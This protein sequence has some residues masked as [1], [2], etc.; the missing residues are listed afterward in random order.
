MTVSVT[1]E[2]RM[3]PDDPQISIAS[4]KRDLETMRFA[5]FWPPKVECGPM[6]YEVLVNW[7]IFGQNF[8]AKG[9]VEEHRRLANEERMRQELLL[10]L[11]DVE[12]NGMPVRLFHDVPDGRFWPSREPG[13][14][15]SR[16][17]AGT[18]AHD[19]FKTTEA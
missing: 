16:P 3:P 12:F 4:L 18:E 10:G 2:A 15:N 13:S 5:G 19:A 1:R 6:V 11:T 8:P 7:T 9:E 14:S 17:F